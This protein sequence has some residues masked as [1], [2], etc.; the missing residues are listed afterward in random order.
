MMSAIQFRLANTNDLDQIIELRILMQLEVNHFSKEN[1]SQDYRDKVKKYFEQSLN[2]HSYESA[3]AVENDIIIGTAGVCFYEKPP[4]ITGGTG[5][6]GYI[7]NVYTRE[8]HRGRGIGTNLMKKLNEIAVERKVDKL[9]L[10][11]T[12]DG[13]SIYK[14]VGYKEPRFVNLEI[15]F[16]N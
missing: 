2:I 10:G 13:V 5:L 6:V 7:T 14:D 1:M 3:I 12:A 11:A 15:K 8:S 4:S 16:N 9:H